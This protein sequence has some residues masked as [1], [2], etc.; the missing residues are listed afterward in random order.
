MTVDLSCVFCERVSHGFRSWLEN[1]SPD[2]VFKLQ[3]TNN[4]TEEEIQAQK[5]ALEGYSA[6]RDASR[7][8]I[9]PEPS[10]S[11][12]S[13]HPPSPSDA[14]SMYTVGDSYPLSASSP[15]PEPHERGA[16][17]DTSV[18]S[19]AS[20]KKQLED[21]KLLT[22]YWQ[23]QFT[24]DHAK[25]A[26]E[27]SETKRLESRL[28]AANEQLDEA[29]ERIRALEAEVEMLRRS[30]HRRGATALVGGP[31]DMEKLTRLMDVRPSSR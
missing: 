6:I 24:Q 22:I 1:S 21:Q 10:T 31:R 27:W 11:N 7:G 18:D 9:S 28:Y 30:R 20:L 14:S 2:I 29:E 12:S 4:P 15:L 13:P 26:K 17:S 5:E 3:I 23:H 8:V 19:I 16:E 25:H